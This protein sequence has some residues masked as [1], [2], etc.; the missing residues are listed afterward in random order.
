MCAGEALSAIGKVSYFACATLLYGANVEGGD[1]DD[2]G[3]DEVLT[4]PG[5]GPVFAPQVRGW[6]VDG[7]AATSTDEHRPLARLLAAGRS[8][9]ISSTVM[10][11]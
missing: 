11:R 7:G 6:N 1:V 10:R 5:P 3:F 9:P 2:D 4:G 8:W